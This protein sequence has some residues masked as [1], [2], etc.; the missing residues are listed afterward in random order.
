MA[1]VLDEEKREQ[2]LALGRLG[3][4]LRRIERELSVR[5][6]TAGAY[7]HA[8]GIAVRRA[9][10]RVSRWPPVPDAR[11]ETAKPATTR[12]VVTDLEDPKPATTEGVITDC[13]PRQPGRAPSASACEP[14][15]DLIEQGLGLGRNAMAI[16]QDLVTDHGFAARYNS[17]RLFPIKLRGQKVPE[18]HPTIVTEPGQEGQ[19]DYGE[20][21]M[22]RDAATGKYRRARLFVFTLGYSR[23]SVRL[24]TMRSSSQIWAELHERA[25][26]RLG[27]TP[28]TVVLD[29]LREGVLKPDW[30]DPTLNPLYRD[31]LRHYG[32]VALPCRPYHPNRK[33]K[34]ESSVG[35]AQRTPLKGLRYETIEA[36]Q[37][38]LDRWE[39]NWADT[40]I[41]GTTKRQV[42][43]MFA[44]EKPDLGVLPV[45]PFRYYQ[46]GNRTVHL[47]G[48]FE[49]GGAYYRAPPELLGRLVP[50]QWDDRCVRLIHPATHLLVREYPIEKR[51]HRQSPPEY[52]PRTTPATTLQLLARARHAGPQVGVLCTEI[53]RRDGEDGVRRILGVLSQAR[54][55]GPAA[56]ERACGLALKAGL[57]TLRFVRIYLENQPE[58]PPMTLL[59][60]DPL[61]RE[62]TH[63]RSYINQ[64]TKET[65]E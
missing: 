26:Q 12:E 27:G 28:K 5:R 59:Q 36:A 41:H 32:V 10:G 35:H 47:D 25:F 51:G 50:V 31:V 58:A 49:I 18:P 1:N 3:W 11:A 22:V 40:R 43:A 34:V 52:Q 63:Y 21:P 7:L 62:L 44:E 20:G 14:Y 64:I 61:I 37:V 38:H 4:S 46:H 13:A 17:V 39:E 2:I 23:K 56:L 60:V 24:L 8:A 16:Y 55:H 19:V 15:R 29:N 45:E 48:C 30:Y 53:H 6:E 33:G 42:S 57:P 65:P 54:K 9:G